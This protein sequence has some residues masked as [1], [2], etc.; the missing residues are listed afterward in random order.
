MTSQI[1][2]KKKFKARHMFSH[3]IC[4]QEVS[5]FIKSSFHF[6]INIIVTISIFPVLKNHFLQC[7]ALHKVSCD[8]VKM[9]MIS[10]HW[11]RVKMRVIQLHSMHSNHSCWKSKWILATYV[12]CMCN[13]SMEIRI[14]GTSIK[15]PERILYD[16]MTFF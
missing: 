16:L 3:S 8:L 14:A 6:Y 10:L 7:S 4:T 2:L 9:C 5:L 13:S 1:C 12:S 11:K 15:L